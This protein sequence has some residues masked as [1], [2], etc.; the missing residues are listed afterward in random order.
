M[1]RNRLMAA[2]AGTIIL[3]IIGLGLYFN[4]STGMGDGLERTM[5]RA[6]LDEPEPI[7]KAPLDYG[8]N[9]LAALTAGIIGFT[10]VLLLTL[11]SGKLLGRLT[12]K[13][14]AA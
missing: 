1:D 11:F 6:D 9:Y 3:F 8:E 13:E 4:F 7:F 12:G 5:E 2:G 14:N 10:V